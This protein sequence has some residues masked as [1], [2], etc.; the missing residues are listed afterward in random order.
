MGVATGMVRERSRGG[1][2][3]TRCGPLGCGEGVLHMGGHV[4]TRAAITGRDGGSRR[5][6]SS[7][8]VSCGRRFCNMRMLSQAPEQQFEASR[9]VTWPN[10]DKVFAEGGWSSEE[11][12]MYPTPLGCAS[13]RCKMRRRMCRTTSRPGGVC[14]LWDP[15]AMICKHR[16][17]HKDEVDPLKERSSE[18]RRG[19]GADIH[20]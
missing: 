9:R 15:G 16:L 7:A 4:V 20:R 11:F 17:A 5:A 18:E 2:G 8:R 1:E 10:S 13:E 19:D 6:C 14:S 12:Q 3:C